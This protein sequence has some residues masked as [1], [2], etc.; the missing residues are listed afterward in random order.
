MQLTNV[1][2]SDKSLLSFHS[3]GW[4]KGNMFGFDTFIVRL[5]M[6]DIIINALKT[7]EAYDCKDLGDDTP[8]KNLQ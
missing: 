5:V 2:S 1:N 4:H 7:W 3:H 6:V 8:H